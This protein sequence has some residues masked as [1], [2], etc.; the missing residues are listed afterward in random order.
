MTP[1]YG[2]FRPLHIGIISDFPI[3]PLE[4][5]PVSLHNR[6]LSEVNILDV[7]EEPPACRLP[8]PRSI[9]ALEVKKSYS[10]ALNPAQIFPTLSQ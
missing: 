8:L 9:G 2:S 7:G 5:T 4:S 3:S 6:T 1:T 10:R